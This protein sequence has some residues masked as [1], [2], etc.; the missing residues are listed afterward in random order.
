MTA[1]KH[2]LPRVQ[3]RYS[4]RI[5]LLPCKQHVI[6]ASSK[7]ATARLSVGSQLAVPKMARRSCLSKLRESRLGVPCVSYTYHIHYRTWPRH[8]QLH[9]LPMECV[10]S[11]AQ[12][13]VYGLLH[14]FRATKL[15]ALCL[16]YRCFNDMYYTFVT[17]SVNKFPRSLHAHTG[18]LIHQKCRADHVSK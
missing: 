10:Y 12:G 15:P 18:S 13:L 17:N 4:C 2:A 3:R 7:E 11:Q 16:Y 6:Q 9:A 1:Q 14:A 5:R 8:S